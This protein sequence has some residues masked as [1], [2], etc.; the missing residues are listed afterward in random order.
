[1]KNFELQPEV[2]SLEEMLNVLGGNGEDDNR[3][4]DDGLGVIWP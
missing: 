1:M 3:D 4:S 2:L